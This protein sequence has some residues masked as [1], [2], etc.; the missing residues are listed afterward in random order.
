MATAI[1]ESSGCFGRGVSGLQIH[2][3]LPHW[4]AQ[5][6]T[7]NILKR[8][9]ILSY[10]ACPCKVCIHRVCTRR[11][12]WGLAEDFGTFGRIVAPG[13]PNIY[14]DTAIT[15]NLTGERWRNQGAS[16]SRCGIGDSWRICGWSTAEG[17]KQQ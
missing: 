4:V 3:L 12:L 15:T 17:E 7:A 5:M 10:F 13:T 2:M 6:Q 1:P 8:G 14:L 16:R 11:G 9:Q